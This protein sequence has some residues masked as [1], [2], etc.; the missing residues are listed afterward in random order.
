MEISKKTMRSIMLGAVGCIVLYW[1]LHETDRIR[2]FL[3]G[4]FQ[5]INPF[6]IGGGL[7]FILNVPMRAIERQLRRIPGM[8]GHRVV[9]I[10]LTILLIVMIF[11]LVFN[12]LMPQLKETVLTIGQQLPGFVDRTERLINKALEDNPGML[13]WVLENT[14]LE[15]YDWTGFAKRVV[16]LIGQGLTTVVNG[17]V[18]AVGGVISSIWNIFLAVVFAL[19]CL[20][21]KET[22]ARQGR[23]LA[24]SVLPEKW[25]DQIIRILRLANTTFSNFFSGQCLEVV[26]LGSLFAVGMSIFRMPYIPLVSVLVAITAFIPVVGAWI[27][28][29]VGA[30]FILVNDPMQAVWFIVLFVVLQ[31]I[32]NNLIYPRVVGTSI[33]LPS[34]WVLVA[35]TLGGELMGVAGMMLMVPLA[36]VLYALLKGFSSYRVENLGIDPEKLRAQPPVL[37][38][39]LKEKREAR[40]TARVSNLT[41]QNAHQDKDRQ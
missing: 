41:K 7:A 12:M 33:G 31:E 24:Y 2:V 40:K 32:E 17:T 34:M 39:K 1:L 16:D 6:I 36:S 13:Q 8:R 30:F 5:M 35:V 37:K 11:V 26:I 15:S 38:S 9:A 22:L 3:R 14:E 19:Y 4:I 27:G 20:S 21:G 29:I 18:T 28:C 25:A 10:I 23:R